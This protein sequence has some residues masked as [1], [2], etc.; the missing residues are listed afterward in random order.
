MLYWPGSDGGGSRLQQASARLPVAERLP[1]SQHHKPLPTRRQ[2]P[3]PR[4]EINAKDK[5]QLTSSHL[6]NLFP[7]TKFSVTFKCFS[8]TTCTPGFA[9]A[10]F[11][12]LF[13]PSLS[14]RAPVFCDGGGRLFKSGASYCC[15]DRYGAKPK[16]TVYW[17]WNTL[18]VTIMLQTAY[19]LSV[20]KK[21]YRSNIMWMTPLSWDNVA[22]PLSHDSHV[23]HQKHPWRG[24]GTSIRVSISESVHM[25]PQKFIN[26]TSRHRNKMVHDKSR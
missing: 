19:H 16:A 26:W 17:L 4:P 2:T 18:L 11:I 23:T 8:L 21:P 10:M 9:P 15:A 24:L 25:Q 22:S 20:G 14:C 12:S 1:Q 5:I 3:R 13:A 6:M 7:F